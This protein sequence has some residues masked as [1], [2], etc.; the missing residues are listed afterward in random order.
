MRGG[1]SVNQHYTYNSP[2]L[3][4]PRPFS[5]VGG[6]R[7][8]KTRRSSMYKKKKGGF[9]PTLMG[10]VLSNGPLLVPAAI[11]QGMRLF[12]NNSRRMSVRKR[13]GRKSTRKGNR[14]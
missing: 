8:R 1:A 11:G 13:K 5:F 14:K 9:Y 6:K 3:A 7:T 12:R 4:L 2:E 10:G